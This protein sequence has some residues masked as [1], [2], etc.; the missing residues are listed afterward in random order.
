[1]LSDEP[2]TIIH[3]QQN[4]NEDLLNRLFNCHLML[5]DQIMMML[6]IIVTCLENE[7]SVLSVPFAQRK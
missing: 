5:K 3:A 6:V 2:N 4:G 7:E 1:M